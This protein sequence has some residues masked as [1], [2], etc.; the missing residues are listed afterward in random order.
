MEKLVRLLGVLNLGLTFTTSAWGNLLENVGASSSSAAMAGISAQGPGSQTAALSNPA[1]LSG[2][3]NRTERLKLQFSVV[4]LVPSF[5]PINNVVTANDYATGTST[6]TIVGNVDNDYKTTLGTILSANYRFG[7]NQKWGAGIFA[8]IPTLQMFYSDS[9]EAYVPEYILHRSRTQRPQIALGAA[10][11]L[12][13]SFSVGFGGQVAYSLTGNGNVLLSQSGSNPSAMRFSASMKPLLQPYVGAA[14]EPSAK[15]A[16]GLVFRFPRTS[17]INFT[18][19]SG[20]RVLGSLGALDFNLKAAAAMSYDPMSIEL[21]Q[22]LKLT[23]TLTTIAQLDVQFWDKFE[24]SAMNIECSSNCIVVVNPSKN[25]AFDFRNIVI[26]RLG[27]EWKRPKWTF[28]SGYAYRPGIIA[29]GA[30]SG[31]GNLLDPSRHTISAGAGFT[32]AK[33]LEFDAP[34]T[35]D[36]HVQYQSLVSEKVTKTSGNEVGAAGSKIGSPGYTVG[37]KLFGAGLSLTLQI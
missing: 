18:L 15:L 2:S 27:L 36:F 17:D 21:A 11:S 31:A 7:E 4:S 9:G 5:D 37:G 22:T 26:P 33:F 32:G 20:A 6:P 13:S 16:T 35:L 8:Y 14:W 23:D 34:Y 28:R 29:Q 12:S 30:L 19:N 24:P 10:R 25:P 1:L 3:S